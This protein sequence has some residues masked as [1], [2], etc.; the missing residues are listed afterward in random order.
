MSQ[1]IESL[2]KEDRIFSPPAAFSANAH[3]RSMEDY[4]ALYRRSIE[5]PE[6]WWAEC[7]Q[8]LSWQR[9]WDSVLDWSEAPFAKWF[10]GGKINASENC[11]DRHVANG[12]GDRVA[13]H[14]V[15]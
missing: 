2:Q 3:V 13:I 10:V 14:W 7:A 11:L 8:K 12:Q 6:E 4:E 5:Y 9:S 15:G 1:N